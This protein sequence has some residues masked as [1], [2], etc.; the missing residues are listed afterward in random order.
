MNVLTHYIIKEVLKGSLVALLILLTLFNLFTLS[1][2]LKDF[3]IG[4][5]GLKEIFLYLVLTSPRVFYELVPFAALLGSLFIVG[6][7]QNHREIIAMRAAGLS[8]FWVIKSVMQAGIVLLILSIFVGEFIAPDAEHKA[9]LLKTIAQNNKVMMRSKYGLWLREKSWFINVRNIEEKGSL[10][11]IYIYELNDENQ[12]VSI[13]QAEH[14][15][16]VGNEL[17]TMSAIKQTEISAQKIVANRQHQMDWKTTINPDLLDATVIKSDN[18]SLYDLF[19]Y[20]DFQKQN[21]QKSQTYELAFWS[22]LINPF[23]T[24]IML[25]VSIP[26]VIGTNRGLSTGERMMIGIV[27]GIMFNIFDKI[28]GSVGLVYGFNPMLMAIFPSLL[29]F[30]GATYAVSRVR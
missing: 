12:L 3:G 29:V 30:C 22:R 24:F 26:F 13:T 19:M 25:L 20:I 16:F 9:Q 27:I 14:A 8:L 28:A 5:Y 15:D 2:E 7:M 17:W 6:S 1:D 21:N 10:S 11:D 18:M 23:I 4:N